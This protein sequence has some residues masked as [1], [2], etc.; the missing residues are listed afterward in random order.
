MLLFFA[1]QINEKV[2][3]EADSSSSSSSNRLTI[4]Q[5][6]SSA[7]SQDTREQSSPGNSR[8]AGLIRIWI[9]MQNTVCGSSTVD[10]NS[11]SKLSRDIRMGV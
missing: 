5:S 9:A 10:E 8:N 1:L 11:I 6:D 2:K 4:E 3:R 7:G